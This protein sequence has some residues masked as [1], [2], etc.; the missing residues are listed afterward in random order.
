MQFK[1]SGVDLGLALVDQ[2]CEELMVVLATVADADM[3][4]D[5]AL[6]AEIAGRHNGTAYHAVVATFL[7]QLAD[8][9][10]RHGA[11]IGRGAD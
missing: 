7:R 9:I 2:G 6:V 10:D 3:Q 4:A 8:A 5:G 1:L 11:K